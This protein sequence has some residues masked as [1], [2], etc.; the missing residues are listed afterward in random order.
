[1]PFGSSCLYE[2]RFCYDG[3]LSGS[4][5]A[6]SCTVLPPADCPTAP[7]GPIAHGSS[8]IY[9][10]T[11]SVPCGSACSWEVRLCTNGSL[12]GSYTN[13]AC[14]PAACA[15]CPNACNSGIT[16]L[17]G[18]SRTC[19]QSSSVPCGGSCAATETRTCNDGSLSGSYANASCTIL[20]C[21]PN[22]ACDNGETCATCPN[23]C[24]ACP[25]GI[26]VFKP[27]IAGCTGSPATGTSCPAM[28]PTGM[29]CSPIGAH[30]ITLAP[31]PGCQSI[32]AGTGRFIF[33]CQ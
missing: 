8:R 30:C 25:T 10:Q 18:Q 11:S 7:G 23:D 5:T 27:P 31:E 24:G 19:Y 26:W 1:M 16:L 29:S 3:T 6:P 14:G 12:S 22:N 28:N 13:L 17:H 21:C 15:N 4:Y 2:P 32:G 33:I 20:P 9:Y